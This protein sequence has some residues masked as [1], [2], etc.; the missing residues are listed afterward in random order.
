[1]TQT[2]VSKYL[3]Q[4]QVQETQVCDQ[5]CDEGL[6]PL[7]IDRARDAYLSF[8]RSCAVGDGQFRLTTRSE[9][10]PFG[11]CFAIFGLQLLKQKK[12][13]SSNA[14]H[15]AERLKTN[16][17]RYKKR[18][19]FI[20]DLA[21]DK[22]FLQLLTFTLSSLY[23]LGQLSIDSLEE[24]VVPVVSRDVAA[25]VTRIGALE[26][27]PQS[28]NRAMFMAI[29]LLHA[30]DYLGIDTQESIDKWVELHLSAMNSR[31][32]WGKGTGMTHLEFQNGYHQYEIFEY[33]GID[34][35][36]A[37]CAASSV[38]TLADWEGHFAPYP[39]GGG[40]YDYDA[41]CI[42][43]SSGQKYNAE[44]RRLLFTTARTVLGEQNA[45]GGFTE[46]HRIRPYSLRN[47][48]AALRHVTSSRG[49]ACME[50]LRNVLTLMHPK[51]DRIHTHWSAYSRRWDES[52]L[53]DSWFRML[54]V[55]RIQVALGANMLNQW[56]FIDYPGIGFHRLLHRKAER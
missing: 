34:N 53:W 37:E 32:F 33:L 40:C 11:L 2:E 12:E 47:I 43:T 17:I 26:G 23:L 13:L 44:R 46:S 7:S 31:G 49:R 10:T 25:D 51:H 55:A 9:V 45:D 4:T 18:R 56:G 27:A 21:Y 16:L 54:A 1:M 41:V 22:P 24:V 28:G 19:E 36:K 30:R 3:E 20:N 8:I 6:Y 35:P 38:E 52:D 48:K 50:R 5:V 42:L 15:F 14:E 39:G 29:V